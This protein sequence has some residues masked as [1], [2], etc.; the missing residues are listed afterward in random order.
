MSTCLEPSPSTEV[1]GAPVAHRMILY[2][3]KA[4]ADGI[5]QNNDQL[6]ASSSP[7]NVTETVHG[8]EIRKVGLMI[9][10]VALLQY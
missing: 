6:S 7:N 3:R 4:N 2:G 1:A 8:L 9:G 5:S 10:F